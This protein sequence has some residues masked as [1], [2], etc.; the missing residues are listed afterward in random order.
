MR[1]RKMFKKEING[2]EGSWGGGGR[3]TNKQQTKCS[4]ERGREREGGSMTLSSVVAE[5]KGGLGWDGV[6]IF[7]YLHA[8]AFLCFHGPVQCLCV[9][10]AREGGYFF[11]FRFFFSSSSSSSSLFCFFCCCVGSGRQTQHRN[12]PRDPTSHANAVGTHTSSSVRCCFL[13]ILK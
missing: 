1:G 7:G 13:Y 4:D 9:C 8:L 2:V 3:L 5:A 6:W 12:L 11:C 10:V